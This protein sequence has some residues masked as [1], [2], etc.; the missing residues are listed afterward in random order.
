MVE[1][2]AVMEQQQGWERPGY[3]LKEGKAPVQP[4]DWYGAYGHALN[5]DTRYVQ[6]L[7]S[8][9]TFGFPKNQHIVN[10]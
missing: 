7:E 4:Y 9:Y 6:A 5:T 3:F 2:G 10:I 8:N 1:L